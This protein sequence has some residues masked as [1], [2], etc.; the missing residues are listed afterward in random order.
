MPY[1]IGREYFVFLAEQVLRE[2]P[3][4]FT[5]YL[6]NI[7]IHVEDYPTTGDVRSTGA[8]RECLLGYFRGVEYPEKGGFFDIPHPLPDKIVL[9]QKNIERICASENELIEEIRATLF[10]EV[11]HY[12]GLAEDDL[13][14]FGY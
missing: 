10:H 5:D 12:F 4:E 7:A 6:T 13:R 11:G 3:A 9:F 1:R 14:R 8:S 2:L